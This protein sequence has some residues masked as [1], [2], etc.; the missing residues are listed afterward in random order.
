MGLSI[1]PS[2]NVVSI[3]Q[4]EHV[5]RVPVV[6]LYNQ[7]D[8]S[9]A[10]SIILLCIAM[11]VLWWGGKGSVSSL[12]LTL[13][14]SDV[15]KERYTPIWYGCSLPLSTQLWKGCTWRGEGGSFHPP[16]DQ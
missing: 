5:E 2:H 14:L 16:R 10:S 8:F 6:G 13:I 9:F 15:T 3:D 7:M 12:V 11:K 1:Q 4:A